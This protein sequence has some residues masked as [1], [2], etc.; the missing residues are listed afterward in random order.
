MSTLNRRQLIQQALR[1]SGAALAAQ[2]LPSSVLYS[3]SAF[4]AQDYKA[5]VC[6]LLAGGCDSFNLLVPRSDAAYAQYGQRRSDLALTQNTLLALNTEHQGVTF[7][8]HPAMSGLQTLFNQGQAACLANIGPLS[9]PTTR[10]VYDDVSSQLPLGLFSHSDQITSWQTATPD[11]RGGTGFGGRL[12]DYL[13]GQNT[14]VTL[15]NN[16]SLSGNNLFQTGNQVG[17]YSLNAQA[18]VRSIGGYID[19][20][21]FKTALDALIDYQ[22]SNLLHNAYASKLRSAIDTGEV[23]SSILA[24]APTL[25]TAFANDNFSASMARIAQLISVREALGVTRQTFFVTYG[26]WDHHDNLL[27]EQAEMLPALDSG[28]SQFALAMDELGLG[29]QVTSFTISDFGRTLTSNG[30]GSDH[31]WGGNALVVGGAV[32]GGQVYGEFPELSQ[33][34]PLDVG[35]GR[36]IPTTA[37]DSLYAQIARW[38]GVAETDLPIVLPNWEAFVGSSQI[39]NLD[40]LFTA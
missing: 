23:V 10:A 2:A 6:V 11:A 31:G 20:P 26:G 19:N 35:R 12:G 22:S 7:G 37:V 24:Q 30:K 21:T 15:A 17:A 4:A 3:A 9:Q 40:G 32:H 38:M 27:S 16:I 33:D 36:F 14:G 34:N 18:G 1:Y 29:T 25:T 5:T 8:L 13:L 28:L 39:S